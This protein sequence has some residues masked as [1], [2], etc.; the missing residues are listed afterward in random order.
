MYPLNVSRIIE[1]RVTISSNGSYLP[2]PVGRIYRIK[3]KIMLIVLMLWSLG[4]YTTSDGVSG[5][6]AYV[7]LTSLAWQAPWD[8]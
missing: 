8:V 7:H 5:Q 2:L 6:Q 4:Y 3:L 1:F